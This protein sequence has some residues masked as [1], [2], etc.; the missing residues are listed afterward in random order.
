MG[1]H[2]S[3][4]I[5]ISPKYGKRL[6]HQLPHQNPNLILTYITT[7]SK[8]REKRR[9][10]NELPIMLLSTSNPINKEKIAQ[11]IPIRSMTPLD[12]RHRVIVLV[13]TFHVLIKI[14][15]VTLAKTGHVQVRLR[16]SA[17]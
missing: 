6:D 15:L 5:W 17:Y 7:P 9:K 14:L 11:S 10:C 13:S 3:E 2:P 16:P 8:K 4:R 1:V 12:T